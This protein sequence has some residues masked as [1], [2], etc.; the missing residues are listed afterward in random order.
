MKCD[1]HY[2]TLVYQIY[3]ELR[4]SS[5]SSPQII[6]SICRMKHNRTSQLI[7]PSLKCED[8][9]LFCVLYHCKL[10]NLGVPSVGLLGQTKSTV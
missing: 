9:L 10:N 2:L 7:G 5:P 3:N 8:L 1:P 4:E 6:N